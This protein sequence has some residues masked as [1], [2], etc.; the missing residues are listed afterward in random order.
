MKVKI[1]A[2][3][4]LVLSIVVYFVS[5]HSTAFGGFGGDDNSQIETKPEE[6]HRTNFWVEPGK[7]Y[8]IEDPGKAQFGPVKEAQ[9]DWLVV[10]NGDFANA[11]PMSHLV[12]GVP[13]VNNLGVGIKT[14]HVAI[15]E[16]APKAE[17]WLST[18]R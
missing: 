13:G 9:V 3:I 10:I 12:T 1:L 11:R 14:V 18:R 6:F 15:P 16:G 17:F 8:K 7:W 2:I 4:G 5:N